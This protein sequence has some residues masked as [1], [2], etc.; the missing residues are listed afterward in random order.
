MD[1]EFEKYFQ[2]KLQDDQEVLENLPYTK[3]QLKEIYRTSYEYEKGAPELELGMES[4]PLCYDTLRYFLPE[5]WEMPRAGKLLY[6]DEEIQ[7]VLRMLI[8]NLGVEKSL[9]VIPREKI[10]HYLERTT[11]RK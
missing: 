3:E 2:Q 10:L 8:F 5:R 7:R 4:Q 1:S 11:K 6:S 9:D